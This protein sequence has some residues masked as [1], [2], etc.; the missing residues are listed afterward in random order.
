MTIDVETVYIDI[1]SFY[2]FKMGDGKEGA[3]V[4]YHM[5][6]GAVRFGRCRPQIARLHEN[7]ATVFFSG[8]L[9]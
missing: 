9:A 3:Q 5:W 7:M 1:E 8:V 2:L 4:Q 6:A